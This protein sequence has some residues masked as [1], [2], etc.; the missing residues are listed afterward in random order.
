MTLEDIQKAV[1]K[2]SPDDLARFRA[3][4]EQFDAFRFDKKTEA[5]ADAGKEDGVADAVI[6]TIAPD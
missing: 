3:W 1:A 6:L 5:G 2:L 4:F